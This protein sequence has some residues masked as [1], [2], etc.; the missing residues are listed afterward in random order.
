MK[1]EYKVK[2]Y[3]I[4]LRCNSEF[5]EAYSLLRIPE[6]KGNKKE[7]RKVYRQCFLEGCEKVIDEYL[8]RKL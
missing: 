4:S 6:L 1:K 3:R 2:M 5:G 7:V 8:K